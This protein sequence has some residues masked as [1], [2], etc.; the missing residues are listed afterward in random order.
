MLLF[1]SVSDD[2]RTSHF[3]IVNATDLTDILDMPLPVL[4]PYQ[5]HGQFFPGL[6][7]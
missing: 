3:H 4:V 2:D 6:F 7:P 1:V 5:A